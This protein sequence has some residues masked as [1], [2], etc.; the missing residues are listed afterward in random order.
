VSR[1]SRSEKKK[2]DVAI[3]GAGI[4]GLS[5]ADE[6]LNRGLSVSIFDKSTPG[7]G[8]SGAPLVLINPATGRRARMVSHAEDCLSLISDLMQRVESF[9]GITFYKKTGILRPALTEELAEDFRRSPEKYDWP[10]STWIS[11]MDKECFEHYGGLFLPNGYTVDAPLYIKH[12]A[13]YLISCGLNATF[14]TSVSVSQSSDNSYTVSLSDGSILEA[15]QIVYATGSSVQDDPTWN[16]LPFKTTKGQLLDLEFKSALSIDHSISSMG[17]LAYLPSQPNRLVVGSTYEHSYRNLDTDSDG[18][19]YLY[20]KLDR[21]LP[22]L[23]DKPHN[24]SMWSGERVSTKDHKPAIGAHPSL[25]G[26]YLLSGLGSKG[27]IQGRY[28]AQ[29]LAELMVDNKPVENKFN[30]NRFLNV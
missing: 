30:L 5:I 28:L 24:V 1:E 6:L 16:F 7:S 15:D 17:Y 13:D 9:S 2:S 20:D 11:W 14:R 12:L 26:L 10:D 4:A 8:S 29:Q 23:R 22:N 3:I 18:K 21:T 19:S 27:M 25:N